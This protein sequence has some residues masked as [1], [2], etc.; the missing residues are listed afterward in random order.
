[1]NAFETWADQQEL[2]KEASEKESMHILSASN[3]IQTKDHSWSSWLSGWTAIEPIS[4]AQMKS[5]GIQ[6]RC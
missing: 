1:L 4:I 2:S 6:L 5:T 3:V